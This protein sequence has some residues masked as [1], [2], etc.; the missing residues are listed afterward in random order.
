MPIELDYKV[1]AAELLP[2]LR[3]GLK[4]EMQQVSTDTGRDAKLSQIARRFVPGETRGVVN[5]ALGANGK[6]WKSFGD[7]LLAIRRVSQGRGMDDRLIF[8]SDDDQ[9]IKGIVKDLA[10]GAGSTGGFLVPEAYRSQLFYMAT[11]EAVI[12]PGA[13]PIP[14]T[15]PTVKIPAIQD[16]SHASSLFGGVIAYWEGEADTLTASQMAL[17][18]K[19]LIA[20][21]LA[22]YT[23]TSNELLA[24]SAIALEALLLLL[25]GMAIAYYEDDAFINGSGTGEPLGIL[26]SPALISVAKETG[27][28]ADTIAWENVANMDARLQP[29]SANHAFWIAS[30]DTKPQLY[31]MNLSVGT[32]GVAV[33]LPA[34]GASGTPYRTLFGRPVVYSEK[35]EQLGDAGDLILVDRFYYLVGS[36]NDLRIDSSIHVKFTTDQTVWRFVERLDGQPWLDSAITPKN[37]GATLSPFVTLAERA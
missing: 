30:P 8:V 17:R 12:R 5:M 16:T 4:A 18:Q 9:G 28:L 31:S 11:E 32:G 10:E 13:T 19:Q 6:P 15:S 26:N 21:K 2:L 3:E 35:A 20:K 34:S 27:Q 29:S 23:I 36:M 24:D 1:I 14:M 37:G 22:G 7:Y 25:F 33:Y